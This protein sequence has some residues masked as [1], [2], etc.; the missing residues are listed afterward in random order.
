M[1]AGAPVLGTEVQCIEE[2]KYK[3]LFQLFDNNT[4]KFGDYFGLDAET[5]RMPEPEFCRAALVSGSTGER[6]KDESGDLIRMISHNRGWLST[7]Y[8]SSPGGSGA[9]FEVAFLIRKLRIKTAVAQKIDNRIAYEPD[10]APAPPALTTLAVRGSVCFLKSRIA[11]RSQTTIAISGI[12]RPDPFQPT[13]EVNVDFPGSDIRSIDLPRQDARLCQQQCNDE[14][15]CRAWTYNGPPRVNRPICWIKSAVPKPQAGEEGTVSGVVRPTPFKPTFEPGMDFRG[16]DYNK[17]DLSDS[18]PRSCQQEC[19][20]DDRGRAWAYNGPGPLIPLAG[21]DRFRKVQ[22]ELPALT[23]PYG[24]CASSC[25]FF[26][27][28]GVDRSGQVNVHRPS[29]ADKM[30][31]FE[32]RQAA[33]DGVRKFYQH[34]DAGADLIQVWETTPATIVRPATAT[35]FPRYLNDFLLTKCR[36]D[37]ETLQR[38]EQA[39]IAAADKSKLSE[40]HEQRREVERC[41]AGE[42]ERA[43]LSAFDRLC[44]TECDPKKLLSE[45]GNEINA[46][47]A[48]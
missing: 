16:N 46:M 5:S 34:M 21:W 36:G 43:R 24:E 39:A 26:H 12:V 14:P 42:F 9:V 25:S 40:L 11:P 28:G 48:K 22:R 15:R 31:D 47:L 8:L 33:G 27:A 23:P 35:R 32:S 44:G 19:Q 37:A 41:V 2:S 6:G 13:Y 3:Y 17:I 30:E 38:Q 45:I 1:A 29:A 20:A 10:F 4:R 18:D 7:I